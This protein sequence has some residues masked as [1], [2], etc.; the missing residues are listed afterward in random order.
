MARRFASGFEMVLFGLA[1]LTSGALL[2]ERYLLDQRLLIAPNPRFPVELSA[3]AADAGKSI[4]RWIDPKTQTWECEIRPGFQ[5]P[6]C[7]FQVTTGGLDLTGYS[8][9]RL[10]LRYEGAGKTLR[11]FVRN[12]NVAYATANDASTLKYNQVEIQTRELA[13]PSTIALSDFQVASWWLLQRHIPLELSKP[14][15]DNVWIVE[16]QTGSEAPPGLHRFQI[17][18]IEFSGQRLSGETFYLGLLLGWLAV[19]LVAL[20]RRLWRL[21]SEVASRRVRE[22]E[23]VQLNRLLNIESRT[24]ESQARTDPL[25]GAA[26]RSG[27]RD[28][29]QAGARAW[30]EEGRPLS[31]ILI[32]LDDFK[33]VNDICGHEGGDQVLVSLVR[34]VCGRVRSSDL[35]ARWGGD[36][37]VVVCRD[38][39]LQDAATLARNL[40]E[41]FEREPLHET[42]PVSASFGVAA[43]GQETISAMFRRADQ[44]LYEAK[45]TGRNMVVVSREAAA[46][47]TAGAELTGRGRPQA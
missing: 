26:N 43:L 13:S 47:L 15:F 5:Y 38:T 28:V 27:M 41:G 30:Q 10:W 23:L 24:Y 35:V 12:R 17:Q 29:L 11:I 16:V 25:T 20:L 44:A 40:R 36:E 14:E 45:R 3:D 21:R 34:L 42:C 22:Q 32:D 39:A 37:F 6:Y 31:V 2:S 19:I 4:A 8:R 9:I 18:R 33:A 7:S 1:L 46:A